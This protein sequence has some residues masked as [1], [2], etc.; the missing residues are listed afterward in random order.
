MNSAAHND[1]R[2]PKLLGYY[3]M[4]VWQSAYQLL[5][6]VPTT[7]TTPFNPHF[8]N[9]VLDGKGRF[10]G[11]TRGSW[12][13]SG[14]KTPCRP[15]MTRKSLSFHNA[16]VEACKGKGAILT[17]G[18]GLRRLGFQVGDSLL[19]ESRRSTQLRKP[20]VPRALSS[21]ALTPGIRGLGVRVSGLGLR[22]RK[23]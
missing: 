7:P 6:H 11:L 22:E 12:G 18:F 23:S 15:C 1:H 4:S 8:I 2:S 5:R 13:V 16:K 17:W 20:E 19:R 10:K 3:H 9:L 14:L 21:K